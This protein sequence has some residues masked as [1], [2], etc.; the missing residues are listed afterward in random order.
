MNFESKQ[1]QSA[2]EKFLIYYMILGEFIYAA[3]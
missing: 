2:V 3:K 1:Y